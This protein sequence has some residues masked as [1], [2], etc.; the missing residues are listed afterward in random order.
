MRRKKLYIQHFS[1]TMEIKY[2]EKLKIFSSIKIQNNNTMK[3]YDISLEISEGMV[4]WKNKDSKRPK[5]EVTS[6]TRT[7]NA[8]ESRLHLDSHTGTHVD[9]PFH[10]LQNGKKIN[11]ISTGK[12]LGECVVVDLTKIKKRGIEKED[13]VNAKV[14]KNDIVILKTSNEYKKTFDF[15]FV[16]LAESGAKFLASKKIKG[17]GINALGIERSQ[18]SY[19]THKSLLGKGIIIFEGLELSEI[20]PGRYFF[21]GLP[22][23]VKDADGAPMRAVLVKK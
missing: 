11:S 18:P 7:G 19:G 8:N 4:V 12:F 21:V 15:N 10:F 17:V 2:N 14:R 22:L 23:K 13:L 20:K 1:K 3:I 6:T 16:Y 9:A 5:I